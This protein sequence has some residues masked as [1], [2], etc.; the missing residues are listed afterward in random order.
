MCMNIQNLGLSVLETIDSLIYLADYE[1]HELVYVNP[2]GEKIFNLQRSDWE[3]KKYYQVLLGLDTQPEICANK[4]LHEGIFTV[5]QRYNPITDKYFK[6][7]ATIKEYEG[8]KMRFVIA[9]DITDNIN[10]AHSLEKNLQESD[11]LNSCLETL[12]RPLDM[13]N[14]ID[15]ILEM[16]G[17]YFNADRIHIVHVKNDD[18]KAKDIFEWAQKKDPVA[19]Q[20]LDSLTSSQITT[21]F[22][23]YSVQDMICYDTQ[24]LLDASSDLFTANGVTSFIAVPLRNDENEIIGFIGVV[25]PQENIQNKH[26][27]RSIAKFYEN[28][29]LKTLQTKKLYKLS[30]VD[31]MTELYN[32][33]CFEEKY[34][35]LT[36]QT[37]QNLGVLYIDLNDLKFTNDTEGHKAGDALI[38][39]CAKIIKDIFPE[40]AY[41]TGGDEF[42]VFMEN[43]SKDEFE[44]KI[45]IFEENVLKNETLRLSC[46]YLWDEG[47]MRISEHIF[48][49]EAM[50][51]TNKK[52]YYANLKD[53]RE[54][55]LYK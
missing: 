4:N 16:V 40:H 11:I 14:A 15:S 3:N 12:I 27:A 43:V 22:N 26:L 45:E 41:R 23:T 7:H 48:Q 17:N 44:E 1:T 32:R 6:V 20:V 46:G 10:Y 28:Y 55:H 18:T 24:E 33:N 25:N 50:M 49:A 52:K 21:W 5:W 29:Y 30:H 13:S 19:S 2:L 54:L 38:C 47:S 53:R 36:E 8:N 37:Y 35:L 39:S 34:Q 51:Y 42:V 31:S 9:H